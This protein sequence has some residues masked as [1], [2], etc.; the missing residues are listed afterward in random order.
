MMKS[1]TIEKWNH[2]I[3]SYQSGIEFDFLFCVPSM[4]SYHSI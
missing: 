3:D 1:F 2:A 4:L